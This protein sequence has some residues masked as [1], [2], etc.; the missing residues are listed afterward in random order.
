MACSLPKSLQH[1][2][3]QSDKEHNSVATV[4]EKSGKLDF[5]QGQGVLYQVRQI[6]NPCSESLKSLGILSL[7]FRKLY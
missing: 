3:S 2:T 7:S 1:L 6:L 5:I 4:M